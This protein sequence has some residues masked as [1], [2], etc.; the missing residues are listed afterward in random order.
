MVIHGW[1][2]RRAMTVTEF[3]FY[4]GA[5][6]IFTDYA[7]IQGE[8]A[9]SQARRAFWYLISGSCLFLLL[10]WIFLGLSIIVEWLIKSAFD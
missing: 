2:E 5:Y 7:R 4:I 6:F 10:F 8:A 1:I 9:S 3:V